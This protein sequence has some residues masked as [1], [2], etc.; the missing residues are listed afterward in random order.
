MANT[1]DIRA[2]ITSTVKTQQ[3]TKAMKMVSAAKLRRA[4]NAIT[5]ARPYAQKIYSVIRKIQETQKVSHPLLKPAVE[6]GSVLVVVLTSDRGL[7]AGFNNNVIKHAKAFYDNNKSN[8]KKMDFIFVGKKGSDYFRKKGV[9]AKETILNLANEIKYP[10]A[11]AVSERL[12]KAY[13]DGEY[14]EIHVVYNEFKSAIS[15][16]VVDEVLMPVQSQ[17]IHEGTED[18]FHGFAKDFIFEPNVETVMD[19]LI[20]KH[21]AIQVYRCMQ[22]SIASEHGA[23]MAA[24]E[25]AT[26]NAGEMIKSLTLTYNKIRQASITTELIE[27]TSGAEALKA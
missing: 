23:R 17:S 3:T 2:K 26:K 27:I 13:R 16:I 25:N 12:W 15:Q 1:K 21:F 4:Q 24:M 9:E 6:H 7:C 18:S 11:E 5:A 22:E 20:E 10:L 14:D 8:Y 19:Q